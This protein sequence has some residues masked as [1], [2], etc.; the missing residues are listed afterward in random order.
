LTAPGLIPAGSLEVE[1]LRRGD[2]RAFE[3]LYRQHCGAVFGLT[4]RLTGR[5]PEAEEL[6]QEVFVRA[7]EHRQDFDNPD[8]FRRWL[9]KV[10][11]NLWLT[12][13]RRRRP[14]ALAD[15]DSDAEDRVLDPSTRRVA[16]N[17]GHRLDLERAIATLSERLRA[18]FVLFDVYGYRHEE[19]GT[20]LEI[21]P[22]SSKV[23]LHRA[24]RRLQEM[25]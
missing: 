20:M 12:E 10:A 18:V 6:T 5:A 24:R 23:L 7:W 15:L 1:R 11:V 16:A 17:S 25:L 19:I 13:T 2:A 21:T 9:R 14:L 22:G 3:S 4:L 8:H